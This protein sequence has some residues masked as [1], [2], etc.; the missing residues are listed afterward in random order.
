MNFFNN[1]RAWSAELCLQVKISLTDD[2]VGVCLP[3]LALKAPKEADDKIYIC[4]L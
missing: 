2:N 3:I 4:E 1:L